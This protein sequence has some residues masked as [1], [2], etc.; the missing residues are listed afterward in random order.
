M[1]REAPYRGSKNLACPQNEEGGREVADAVGEDA[2]EKILVAGGKLREPLA[3][4]RYGDMRVDFSAFDGSEQNEGDR[5]RQSRSERPTHHAARAQESEQHDGAQ[6]AQHR[7]ERVHGA[8]EAKGAALLARCHAVRQKRVARWPAATAAHPPECTE[9]EHGGPAVREGISESREGGSQVSGKAGGL[10]P[11]RMIGD[12]TA[13]ELGETRKSVGDS[14]DDA[15]GYRR[16]AQAGE[17]TGQ[18]GRGSLV[19]PVGEKTGEADAEDSAREPAFA[20]AEWSG[21][22][23]VARDRCGRKFIVG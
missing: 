3:Q 8:L 21:L 19:S 11:A 18:D 7:A 17:K 9:Q 14:F 16:R 6:R 22:A 23:H 1:A 2:G 10:S 12:E 4:R 5:S 20:C 15:Q 13:G